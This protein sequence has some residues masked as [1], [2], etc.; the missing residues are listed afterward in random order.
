MIF[1]ITTGFEIEFIEKRNPYDFEV[2]KERIFAI[3]RKGMRE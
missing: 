1:S 2:S 3:G